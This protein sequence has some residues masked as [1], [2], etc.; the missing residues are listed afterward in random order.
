MVDYKEKLCEADGCTVI[1]KPTTG[2]QKYCVDCKDKIKHLKALEQWRRKSRKK[3]NSVE[4]IKI[5]PLCGTEFKTFYK[6]KIYCGSEECEN[7]RVTIKNHAVHLRRDKEYLLSKGRRYYSENKEDILLSKAIKYREKNPDAV[8]YV[9]GRTAKP[10]I[11]EVKKVI[12]SEGYT[13][14]STEYVNNRTKLKL[15]CPEGHI[16]FTSFHNF[17]DSENRCA[18]CYNSYNA[19]RVCAEVQSGRLLGEKNPSYKGGV[20][21]L[22]Y[23]AY[24]TYALK[25]EWCEEVRPIEHDGFEILQ[26]R[27]TNSNCRQWFTPTYHQVSNRL[28]VINGKIEGNNRFYCCNECKES[29]NIFNKS[30]VEQEKQFTP[31][32]LSIWSKTVLERHDFICEYCGETANTAHH[33]I[34]KKLAPF[35]A[36]DPDNGISCCEECHYK[37]GH[38]SEECQPVY[39]AKVVCS[40]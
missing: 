2:N 9:P 24:D 6:S 17:K 7:K 29:C 27:C 16:W 37:Y 31:Y 39:I 25:L 22:G 11:Y 30:V 10:T 28:Q 12:E 4:Q 13:L 26:V 33:I 14:L 18:V 1:F 15:Q 34:P 19:E 32:E 36:L 35:Y 21:K 8:E 5:C 20:R 38:T 23:A 3:N 40:T